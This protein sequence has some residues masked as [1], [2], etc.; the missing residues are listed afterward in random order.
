MEVIHSIHEI[1]SRSDEHR[2]VL[3][4]G[5]KI[6]FQLRLGCASE[7]GKN[8]EMAL[9]RSGPPNQSSNNRLRRHRIATDRVV[10]GVGKISS[11]SFLKSIQKSG[12]ARSGPLKSPREFTKEYPKGDRNHAFASHATSGLLPSPGAPPGRS[13]T[14]GRSG[15]PFAP[16]LLSL[17]SR[18]DLELWRPSQMA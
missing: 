8:K 9:G 12:P 17:A 7:R 1:E 15:L 4:I 2:T 10:N 16:P 14:F 5:R 11:Q 18:A 3:Y 13:H 6:R